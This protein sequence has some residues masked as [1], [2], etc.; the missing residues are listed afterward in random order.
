MLFFPPSGLPALAVLFVFQRVSVLSF[1]THQNRPF[2]LYSWKKLLTFKLTKFCELSFPSDSDFKNILSV[3][4][5]QVRNVALP[6]SLGLIK[7]HNGQNGRLQ[8]I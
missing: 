7:L 6:S 4:F 1:H 3:I 8:M 5:S 2:N